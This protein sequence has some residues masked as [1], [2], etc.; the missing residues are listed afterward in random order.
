ME[1]E[2]IPAPGG[3]G[4]VP[5]ANLAQNG[6]ITLP[7]LPLLKQVSPRQRPA[8]LIAALLQAPEILPLV[9]RAMLLKEYGI[10]RHV[11]D[12]VMRAISAPPTT[13][14]HP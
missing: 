5:G 1:L 11:G 7:A 8:T 3:W 10:G 13:K 14:D 2:H 9:T 6:G 4:F 12:V